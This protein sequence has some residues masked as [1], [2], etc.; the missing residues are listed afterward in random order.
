MAAALWKNNTLQELDLAHNEISDAGLIELAAALGATQHVAGS[1]TLRDAARPHASSIIPR[2]RG[3]VLS[4][5]GS[6]CSVESG[7]PG[8]LLLAEKL[9]GHRRSR[10]EEDTAEPARRERALSM[11]V[12]SAAEFVSRALPFNQGSPRSPRPH[13]QA[14]AMGMHASPNTSLAALSVANNFPTRQGCLALLDALGRHPRLTS[15]SLA[16]LP[17]DTVPSELCT[18]IVGTRSLGTLDLSGVRL[19]APAAVQLS[20]ALTPPSGMS[21]TALNLSRN[22]IG[23]E[24]ATAL[25]RALLP[26]ACQ[27]D[28]HGTLVRLGHTREDA[29]HDRYVSPR[30]CAGCTCWPHRPDENPKNEVTWAAR[31]SEFALEPRGLAKEHVHGR[32]RSLDLRAN[33][34]GAPG[35]TALAK[36][37]EGYTTLKNLNLTGNSAWNGGATALAQMVSRNS[38]LTS[39]FF[40]DGS[41]GLEGVSRMAGAIA[42]APN[43]KNTDAVFRLSAGPQPHVDAVESEVRSRAR[44]TRTKSVVHAASYAARLPHWTD[45]GSSQERHPLATDGRSEF[46]DTAS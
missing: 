15:L 22:R 1:T 24:G 18:M 42:H 7:K 20:E 13:P 4:R 41:V 40:H 12:D 45:P 29:V 19:D 5:V 8:N 9:E 36:A 26:V 23:D 34:I 44:H 28:A 30:A 31:R 17:I 37:L 38:T 6:I 27:S 46:A 11:A 14:V 35:I 3:S 33:G 21:L 39:L 43:L 16:A 2:R 10:H 32:L 25:A